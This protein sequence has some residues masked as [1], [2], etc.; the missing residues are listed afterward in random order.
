MNLPELQKRLSAWYEQSRRDLPWR[1]TRDPY[2]IWISEVMLQQT[3][4]RT[5]IPYYQNFVARFPDVNCLAKAEL[6]DLLKVWEGLGYYARARN[7]HKAAK[8][9]S[10]E[11]QGEI[12]KAFTGLKQL[13]G[14]GEYTASAIASIAF[15]EPVAVLDGNVKRVLARWEALKSD[16][17]STRTVKALHEL[18]RKYLVQDKPGDWNQAVM[19]LGAIICRPKQPNCGSCPAQEA[20]AT[21]QKGLVAE[22]PVVSRRKPI[23]HYDVTAGLIWDDGKLLITQRKENGFLGGL[24]EFPGG[25]QEAGESLEECL[26]RELH[27]ELDISVNV[28]EK[29]YTLKHAYTHF[30]ITLH[31]YHCTIISGTPQAIGCQRWLWVDPVQLDDFTFPKA[32]RSIIESVTSQAAANSEQ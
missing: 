2:L 10:H 1:Q 17:R 8:I 14:V 23:P 4:A 11:M 20:C 12:P 18:A 21:F 30:R 13:P 31:I 7:L 24:W 3:Q 6:S 15:D 16:I 9:V 29:A 32:D 5:V 19:E 22:I 25:K 27:E 26:A 28:G